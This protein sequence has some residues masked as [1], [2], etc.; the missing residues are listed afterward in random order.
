M[1]NLSGYLAAK[2]FAQMDA[3]EQFYDWYNILGVN[4]PDFGR[5]DSFLPEV[6]LE[7]NGWSAYAWCIQN[8]KG[9]VRHY[10]RHLIQTGYRTKQFARITANYFILHCLINKTNEAS[11]DQSAML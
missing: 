2:Q 5:V 7:E 8:G 10:H 3:E 9:G 4:Q 1:V 11:T 6:M